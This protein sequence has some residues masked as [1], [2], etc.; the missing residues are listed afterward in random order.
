MPYVAAKITNC[1]TASIRKCPWI[2]YFN[3]HVVGVISN[4]D[5]IDIDVNN[6]CYDWVDRKYYKTRNPNGWIHDGV[7]EFSGG[8]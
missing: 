2:P 6:V 4:G 7:V 1:K 8:D 3:E 5:V